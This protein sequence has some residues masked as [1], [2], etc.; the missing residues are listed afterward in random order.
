VQK[1]G[2]D[3]VAIGTDSAYFARDA[4][5]MRSGLPI[6]SSSRLRWEYFWPPD[7]PMLHEEVFSGSLAEQSL[8]W[9]N[10]PLFTVG[11]VQR[12]FRDDVIRKII[13]G[14][15][16][17]VINAAWRHGSGCEIELSTSLA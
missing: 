9:T 5:M 8:A 4:A 16:L 6:T 14:N 1:Y 2:A 7:D 17:R 10:W 3:G 13:G 15:L 12:G 11:L